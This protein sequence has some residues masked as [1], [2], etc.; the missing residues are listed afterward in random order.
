[1]I[2][3]IVAISGFAS[4]L[5][6]CVCLNGHLDDIEPINESYEDFVKIAYFVLLVIIFLLSVITMVSTPTALDVYQGKTVLKT[7]YKGDICVDS[8]VVFK[9]Q[10]N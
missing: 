7:H 9:N 4:I 6:F 10:G 5:Y 2:E 8:T 3:L 1:M